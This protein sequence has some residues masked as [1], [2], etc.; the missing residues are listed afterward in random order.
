MR[1]L[2]YWAVCYGEMVYP[3]LAVW[4]AY[5]HTQQSNRYVSTHCSI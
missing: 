5:K 1:R 4:F 2:I 3:S